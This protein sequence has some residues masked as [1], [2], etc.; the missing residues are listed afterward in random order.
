MGSIAALIPGGSIMERVS[1]NCLWTT[2]VVGSFGSLCPAHWQAGA[3]LF[4]LRDKHPDNMYLGWLGSV[5]L[6][7]VLGK[8]SCSQLQPN[9]YSEK[10]R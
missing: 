3:I 9:V 5:V 1:L 4:R 2:H 6:R 10:A 8:N 7:R